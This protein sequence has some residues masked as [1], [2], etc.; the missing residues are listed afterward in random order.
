M[1]L[2]LFRLRES[3]LALNDTRGVATCTQGTHV[4][5]LKRG[6]KKIINQQINNINT[7]QKVKE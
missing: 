4:A 6:G 7:Q 2:V 5:Y 1:D 3:L